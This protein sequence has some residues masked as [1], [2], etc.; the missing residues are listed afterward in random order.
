MIRSQSRGSLPVSL[1]FIFLV[2]MMG[3]GCTL[4]PAILGFQRSAANSPDVQ[5]P[6]PEV[7]E[8]EF[9]VTQRK[10]AAGSRKATAL[11]SGQKILV[12]GNNYHASNNNYGH[13]GIGSM[14]SEVRSTPTPSSDG[15]NF[16]SISFG[17]GTACALTS[18]FKVK[19][20]G[21][22]AG[23]GVAG[24]VYAPTPINDLNFNYID[25]AAGSYHSCALTELGKAYCWG[26]GF[27][28]KLGDLSSTLQTSPVAAF[29]DLSFKK[30]TAGRN[31]T[32]AIDDSGAVMCWGTN[33]QG[34]LG[35]GSFASP[36]L[37]AT[38]IL[39]TDLYSDIDAGENTTCGI[40]TGGVLK[41]WGNNSVYQLSNGTI[42][43]SHSPVIVDSGV[44]YKKISV[45]GSNG[46]HVCGITSADKL[47]CWGSNSNGQIGNG[48]IGGNQT[49]PLQV[50]TADYEE[51]SA[52]GGTTCAKTTA[53]NLFCWGQNSDYQVGNGVNTNQ[54]LP[55]LILS[56]L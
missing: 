20:W 56:G 45:G 15:G 11:N 50:G 17:E 32:C 49:T 7:P 36:Q 43:N 53:G 47:K 48:S 3:A 34:Q 6:V 29:P 55:Q 8:L 10:I 52:G 41:C 1:T 9:P 39:D 44:S 26:D 21:A 35:I 31:H 18:D 46:F 12:W 51:I 22:Y 14:I 25:I 19:C 54:S 40:T 24:D 27:N 5:R 37:S 16:I 13:L 42:T 4:D 30:I 28:G 33:S 23:T 38:A 2:L